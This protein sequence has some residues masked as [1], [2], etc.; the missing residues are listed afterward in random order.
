MLGGSIFQSL[1]FINIF[2]SH[3][4]LFSNPLH[5]S[6]HLYFL[7]PCVSMNMQLLILRC[8]PVLDASE[9]RWRTNSAKGTSKDWDLEHSVSHPWHIGV[10]N[11]TVSRARNGEHSSLHHRPMVSLAATSKCPQRFAQDLRAPPPVLSCLLDW[12]VN[13]CKD[14]EENWHCWYCAL[15]NSSFKL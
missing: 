14:Q 8:S 5:F 2:C 9:G 6:H 10:P 4:Q 11:T 1:P 3:P 15:K 7:S 12:K 13:L